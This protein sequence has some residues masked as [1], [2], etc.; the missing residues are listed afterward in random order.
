[1]EATDYYKQLFCSTLQVFGIRI[2]AIIRPIGRTRNRKEVE[3]SLKTIL[4][5]I[6]LSVK[7]EECP[8][9]DLQQENNLGILVY[10]SNYLLLSDFIV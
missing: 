3:T 5:F 8:L 1:M 10:G 7:N 4:S 6:R 9:S 2:S